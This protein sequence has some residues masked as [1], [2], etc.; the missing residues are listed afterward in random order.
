[1]VVRLKGVWGVQQKI[2]WIRKMLS[3]SPTICSCLDKRQIR[4]RKTNTFRDV[5]STSI[6]WE[7]GDT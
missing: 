2:E 7:Y 6:T 1:M 4:K 3:P 5:H